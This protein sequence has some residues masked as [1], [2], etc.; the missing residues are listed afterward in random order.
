MDLE[1]LLKLSD[2]LIVLFRG[3]IMLER[4]IG[5][6]DMDELALAMAGRTAGAAV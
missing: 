5:D 4:S 6:L 3:R 2:R 1:E